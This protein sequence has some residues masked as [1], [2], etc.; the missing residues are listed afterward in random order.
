MSNVLG[1]F[2]RIN[3]VDQMET[4]IETSSCFFL[5]A[6]F[7]AYG[8]DF[9]MF[10]MEK[11]EMLCSFCAMLVQ[12]SY[13]SKFG[14]IQALKALWLLR[15]SKVMHIQQE[16]MASFYFLLQNFRYLCSN[17]VN[18]RILLYYKF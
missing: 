14:E 15:Y 18:Q 17:K 7:H 13:I 9:S 4:F 1:I 8:L 10:H 6:H 11:Q 16:K 2:A 12:S 5:H 3:N